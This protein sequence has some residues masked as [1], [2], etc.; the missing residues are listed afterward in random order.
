MAEPQGEALLARE[1]SDIAQFKLRVREGLRA[2]LEAEAYRHAQSINSEI[3]DRLETSLRESESLGG[4]VQADTIDLLRRVMDRVSHELGCPWHEDF[5]G[6][7]IVVGTFSYLVSKIA[8]A[9]PPLDPLAGRDD[10]NEVLETWERKLAED[11]RHDREVAQRIT[12]LHLKQEGHGLSAAERDEYERL[13]NSAQRIEQEPELS[14]SDLRAW[15]ISQD[16]KRR[17][18]RAYAGAVAVLPVAGG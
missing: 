9:E 4:G 7:K 14:A 10:L 16:R 18:E 12:E 6:A 5:D 11:R 2:R 3:I 17:V 8:P 1:P 15:R 13:L